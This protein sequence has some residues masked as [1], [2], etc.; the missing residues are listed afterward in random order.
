MKRM[1]FLAV[2]VLLA[3]AVNAQDQKKGPVI[4]FAEKEKDFGDITQGDR[5]EHVFKFT[6]SGDTPLV[7]QNVAVTCGCTAPNWP[8][9]PIAP[10]ANAEIKVIYNSAGKM[11]KQNPIIRV[12]SNASEPIEKIALK[13]NVLPKG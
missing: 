4:D 1:F 9:E 10:G 2:L 13:T 5:V 7:I 12:Y 8:K 3:V 6:N 11:G